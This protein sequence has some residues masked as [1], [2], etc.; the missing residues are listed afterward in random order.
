MACIPL[1]LT[2]IDADALEPH[3]S[4]DIEDI[5]SGQGSDTKL[6]MK[7]SRATDATVD[8]VKEIDLIFDLT[9]AEP[10]YSKSS[11]EMVMLYLNSYDVLLEAHLRTIMSSIPHLVPFRPLE[12][13]DPHNEDGW[14]WSGSS[15]M[16]DSIARKLM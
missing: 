14:L 8:A 11:D 15:H 4:L 12:A 10:H 16:G 5:G 1:Q 13:R 6:I 2:G 7:V 3:T 9:A